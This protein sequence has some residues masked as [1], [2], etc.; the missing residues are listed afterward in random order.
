MAWRQAR[1]T[2][3]EREQI[4]RFV[5]LA[6]MTPRAYQVDA[7]LEGLKLLKRSG[8]VLKIPQGTGK[9][10]VSQLIIRSRLDPAGPTKT[11]ALVIAP[12]IELRKQ[13]A[14]LADWFDRA[15]GDSSGR[16]VVELDDS[17]G[18]PAD[19]IEAVHTRHVLVTTPKFLANR[20]ELMSDRWND[21]DLC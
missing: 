20:L 14:R 9:S 13:Y 15:A 5:K 18:H 10:L 3:S 21:I 11:N 19:F 6:K 16:L 2:L 8:F 4:K 1:L 17:R 12:T 7:T